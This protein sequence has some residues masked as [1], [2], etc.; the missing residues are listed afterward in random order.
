LACTEPGNTRVFDAAPTRSRAAVISPTC[1]T[2]TNSR[3]EF[4]N[5]VGG[6]PAVTDNAG[7]AWRHRS[8]HNSIGQPRNK[9]GSTTAD[10]C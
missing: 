8:G 7:D 4:T 1:A 2:G 9:L 5:I 6:A 3:S 10:A